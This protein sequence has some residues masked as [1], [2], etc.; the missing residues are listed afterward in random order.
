MV[1]LYGTIALRDGNLL[2]HWTQVFLFFLI[3]VFFLFVFSSSRL[4]MNINLVIIL[5]AMLRY[6]EFIALFSRFNIPRDFCFKQVRR[7]NKNQWL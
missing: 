1:Y 2:T 5:Y 6:T 4:I 3:I 7:I